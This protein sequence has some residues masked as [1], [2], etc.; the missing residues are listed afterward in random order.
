[1]RTGWKI[2]IGAGVIGGLGFVWYKYS[3]PPAMTIYQLNPLDGSGQFAWGAADGGIGPGT[4]DAGWGWTGSFAGFTPGVGWTFQMF[5]NA[6]L[7][8]TT[9]ISTVGIITF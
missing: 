8:K 7:Y 1:M 2:A 5:K 9:V 6:A 4:M 3:H